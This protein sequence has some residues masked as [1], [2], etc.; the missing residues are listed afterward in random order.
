[1]PNC[2][3]ICF[4][5]ILC[6][7]CTRL[8]VNNGFP[9]STAL[10]SSAD[11]TLGQLLTPLSGQQPELSG[12]LVLDSGQQALAQRLALTELAERSLDAQ[13]YIWNSDHSGRLLVERLRRAADRG[14]RVRLL[15]DD[16]NVGDRDRQLL[17]LDS[18]A[19][20]EVRVYNPFH[21]HLRGSGR[22]L[23]LIT[24]FS[25][26][27]R[28]M[29]NKTFIADGSAA[30]V[31]GRNIG[32]EYFD[33]DAELNFRDRDMLAVGPIIKRVGDNF[34]AYWNSRWAYPVSTL[35]D[36]LTAEVVEA[37]QQQLQ[38]RL[39]QS[40]PMPYAIPDGPDDAHAYFSAELTKLVWAK[41]ELIFDLPDKPDDPLARP[42]EQNVARRLL[43]L[44]HNTQQEL[45]VESAYLVT[46]E[47]SLELLRTLHDR[48]VRVRALTN[49]LAS[50][51]VVANHAA[52][53]RA[54]PNLLQQGVELYELRPDAP[55]CRRLVHE[56][57]LCEQAVFSLHAKSM[58]F[59]REI[60][61]VGSFN[62]NQ[63]SVYLNS[64]TALIVYSPDLARQVASDIEENLT[65]KNSWQVT[66][67]QQDNLNWTTERKIG[68]QRSE[69][70]PEV[71]AWLRFKA[72]LI[73]SFPLEKYL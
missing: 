2:L 41:A 8:P 54:R 64:E 73:A 51:D 58:V 21:Q 28:R 53:I 48:G 25:R 1:M 66:L 22:W 29:H 52:Y 36:P 57:D 50:N 5:A 33:L 26:L 68:K 72:G 37:L 19:Q 59:D 46:G 43:E 18:H 69:Y 55:S 9:I 44:A 17:A 32:D 45:L 3:I 35:V 39:S 60:L 56:Q 23:N 40:S 4:V 6:V 34:D 20:I 70:E 62:I 11:T 16:F 13:Y 7:G 24:E 27:N 67:D 49:S 65:L 12:F 10:S 15:L 38:T 30:I 31:G 47:T 42:A 14:V 63:R 61:Y 71:S